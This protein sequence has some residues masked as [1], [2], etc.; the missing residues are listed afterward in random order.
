MSITVIPKL[1]KRSISHHSNQEKTIKE[2]REASKYYRHPDSVMVSYPIVIEEPLG[3]LP[4]NIDY[5]IAI[6]GGGAAGI[7]AIYEIS[8]IAKQR[9]SGKISITLYESDYEHFTNSRVTPFTINTFGKKAGRV[10]AARTSST[11]KTDHSVY[12]IGA[13]RFPETAGITW[14]YASIAFGDDT[15]VKI[16]P[17]PGQV[18]TE[19]VF[20]DRVDRY[21]GDKWLDPNS[22]TKWISNEVNK[23][24]FGNGE[25]KSANISLFQ[26]GNK[27]PAKVSKELK[28]EETS[29]KRLEEINKEWENFIIKFD[30][31]TLESAVRKVIREKYN[32]IHSLPAIN[33]ITDK[34]DIINYYVEL[35]G[36]FGFGTGG[37]KPVFNM[38]IVEMM[39]LML[40][41]YSNEFM[42]PVEQNVDFLCKLYE[43]SCADINHDKKFIVNNKFSRVCDVCH[44]D[45][46]ALVFSYKIN[47]KMKE[48]DILEKE[49]YDFVILATPQQELSNIITRAGYNADS[50]RNIKFGDY[51]KKTEEILALPP[52]ILSKSHASVNAN[53]VTAINQLHMTASSK[54]FCTIKANWLENISPVFEG[55]RIKAIL[56]DCGFNSSYVVPSSIKKTELEDSTFYSFLI[57]YAWEDSSKRLQHQFKHYP[58]NPSKLNETPEQIKLMLR[59]MINHATRDIKDPKTNTYQRWWFSKLFEETEITDTLSFD[60]TTNQTSGAFKLDMTGGHYNTNLCFR[61]H[62]HALNPDLNNRFFLASDSYSHLGGWLEGAFMSAINAV[63]GLIVAANGGGDKGKKALSDKAGRVVELKSI[64]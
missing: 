46:K 33:G 36:C 57:S 49:E 43:I 29:D 2:L 22:P 55:E 64:I 62:T 5:K 21:C 31:I 63:S 24:I 42:L 44:S 50:P 40:W 25:L 17:N 52:L 6:V 14:K 34:E 35:F 28:D 18:S 10:F 60:W 56:S 23:G 58:I 7:S 8:R 47:D 1:L 59:A 27:D 53:I 37:F 61:Y 20:G 12:E 38:S 54:V 16:F 19:F 41:N 4:D 48:E 11:R 45:N 39:R 3:C 13:M 51:G 9:S 32:S 30:G 15:K 26:I